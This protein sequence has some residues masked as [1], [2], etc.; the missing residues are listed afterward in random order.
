MKS[1]TLQ[2]LDEVNL[3]IVGLDTTT[4]RRLSTALSYLLP[5]AI[6]TPAYK[7]GRWDGKVAYFTIGGASYINLLPVILPILEEEKYDI[8]LVD[9]RT[10]NR[11][12]EFDLI[13]ENLFADKVWPHGHPIAGQP[14]LL[15][16][17]QVE[18][19]NK[20]FENQQSIQVASTGSGKTVVCAALSSQCEKYGRTIVVVPNK[21]LVL[22]TE[23]DYINVGLDCGVFYGDRKEYDKTHTICTWQSL[24]SLFK[25]TKKGEAAIDFSEF[26][27]GVAGIIV[28]ECFDGDSLVLTPDGKKK[29]KDI[30]PGD[31]VINY[32]EK[33]KI[34]K[35]DIV[36]K[37]HQNLTKSSS[38]KMYELEFD[39]GKIIKCTANHKFLTSNRGWV[40]AD[41]LLEED[42]IISINT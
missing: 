5:Y 34:F 27:E 30:Q 35:E 22:Q 42:D 10:H 38:E 12:F 36:I 17:Y 9:N 25:K 3:K 1:C 7:L 21:S 33:T 28:D 26:I 14:I 4:R 29:I 13:D 18:I 20:F 15:R 41:E 6:H 37:Q 24:S 23:A 8:E 19:V 31:A 39:N 11:S 16:D 32:D 40:R 2:I